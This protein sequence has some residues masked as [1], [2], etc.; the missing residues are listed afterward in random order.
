MDRILLRFDEIKKQIAEIK[1]ARD[2]CQ[3]CADSL[4]HVLSDMEKSLEQKTMRQFY[5]DIT[6]QER[7]LLQIGE[8]IDSLSIALS[9]TYQLFWETE[10]SIIKDASSMESAISYTRFHAA[11]E[12]QSKV[13]FGDL[14]FS[15]T[16]FPDWIFAAAQN[17]F[18]NLS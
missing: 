18:N 1:T 16:V 5:K 4:K 15:N 9:K 14:R 11:Q 3:R 7:K 13:Y 12:T 8:Q 17:H 2:Q 6:A 10:Q